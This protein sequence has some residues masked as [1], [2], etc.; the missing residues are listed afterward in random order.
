MSQGETLRHLLEEKRGEGYN[1]VGRIFFREILI[2]NNEKI[3][4][5]L[6][7]NFPVNV[8]NPR[9]FVESGFGFVEYR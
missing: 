8:F 9:T 7:G 2:K 4:K 6:A 5:N 1:G 3:A